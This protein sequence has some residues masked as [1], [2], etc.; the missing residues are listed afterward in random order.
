MI[1]NVYTIYDKQAEEY[2]PIFEAKNDNVAIRKCKIEFKDLPTID[3]FSL[4]CIGVVDHDDG[5]F[6]YLDVDL[7]SQKVCDLNGIFDFEESK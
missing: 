5:E 3:D 2:G 6:D 7:R 4:Y 1:Y